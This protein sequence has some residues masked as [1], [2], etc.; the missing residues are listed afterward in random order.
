[1]P[2]P[3]DTAPPA[4]PLV[5]ALRVAGKP[6]QIPA[7]GESAIA[8]LRLAPAQNNLQ[9]EFA[10]VHFASGEIL[11]YQYMLES[12]DSDWSPPA[13]QR[14]VNYASL[15]PGAYRFIVRAVN[16]EGRISAG[17]ASVGFVILPPLWRTPR[18]ISLAVV[19]T[20]A[21]LYFAYR[22]RLTQAL[23]I[24]RIRTRL[25]SDLH[26]DIGAGLAEIA[27]LS[28]VA[29]G[30]R[31][32]DPTDAPLRIGDRARQ[33]RDAM[34]DIVWS[35]D[36][37]H[38]SL[39]GLI[40]RLRQTVYDMADASSVTVEFSAPAERDVSRVALPPDRARHVLLIAK[41][42]LTNIAKHARARTILVRIAVERGALT[43]EIIDDGIGF[44]PDFP[45]AGMGLR[46]LRRRAAESLGRLRIESARD[47]GT[48][49][50]LTLP[51]T[52]SLPHRPRM[53]M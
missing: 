14:I 50:L 26:D 48:R 38:G 11:R 20:A 35:V 27:I 32:G 46:N 49:V 40:A 15:A 34:S 37:R 16:G 33:L 5:R 13:E 9:I 23:R 44:D 12:A 17:V 21:L 24:E 42:A 4:A 18:F 47:H 52:R 29:K 51:L 10:S 41:E 6:I 28:E 2:E 53:T 7:L 36:P 3:D 1:V 31:N 30:A 19:L 8:G 43:L 22:Y 25:A 39:A 45:S